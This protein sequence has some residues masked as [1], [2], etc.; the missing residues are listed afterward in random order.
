MANGK[1]PNGNGKVC[2]D[3]DG[4]MRCYCATIVLANFLFGLGML[5]LL[6]AW[7]ASSEGREVLGFSSTH[8][9]FD[10]I[11]FMVAANFFRYRP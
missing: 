6:F 11:A 5:A 7:I 4:D 9:F 8:L 10:S 2:F 1:K 3:C